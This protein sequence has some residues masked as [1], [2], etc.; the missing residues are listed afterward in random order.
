[1]VMEEA[2]ISPSTST[3]SALAEPL[4]EE[5]AGTAGSAP[6]V[7]TGLSSHD[8]KM[9]PQLLE[10]IAQGWDPAPAMPHPARP[11]GAAFTAARRQAVSALF[12]GQLVVVPAGNLKT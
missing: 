7:E 5:P 1:R 9:A 12:A 4:S 3:E 2:S 6:E 11:D 10:A 8:I